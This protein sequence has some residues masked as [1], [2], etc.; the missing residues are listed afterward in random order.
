VQ[1]TLPP[2]NLVLPRLQQ[3]VYASVDRALRT[4]LC[5][6]ADAVR[7]LGP[8]L[9]R[10]KSHAATTWVLIAMYAIVTVLLL[11]GLALLAVNGSSSAADRARVAIVA[12]ILVIA[13]DCVVSWVFIDLHHSKRRA[14]P[15]VD[16]RSTA[17]DDSAADGGSTSSG[18]WTSLG[19]ETRIHYAPTR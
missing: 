13:A 17:D 9:L 18:L 2:L 14:S 19:A 12:A 3:E 4:V 15:S 8:A 7:E 16:E 6:L 5:R 11:T 1:L 10:L